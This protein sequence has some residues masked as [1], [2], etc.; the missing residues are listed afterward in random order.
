MQ[1]L[2]KLPSGFSYE[3]FAELAALYEFDGLID[4]HTACCMA[5]EDCW[6]KHM[7]RINKY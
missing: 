3:Y 7:E 4:R 5:I 6:K 1:Y 2:N